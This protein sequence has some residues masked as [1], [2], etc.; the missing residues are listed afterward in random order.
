MAYGS[1]CF[2]G[3]MF[4]KAVIPETKGKSFEQIQRELGGGKDAKP[5]SSIQDKA[6]QW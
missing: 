1:V 6:Y 5:H 4:V 3:A 2:L